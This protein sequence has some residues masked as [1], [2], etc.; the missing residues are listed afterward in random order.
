[1]SDDCPPLQ[2][3]LCRRCCRTTNQS[4][5][6]SDVLIKTKD[7]GNELPARIEERERKGRRGRGAGGKRQT[8]AL[9]HICLSIVF[10]QPSSA[11]TRLNFALCEGPSN[12]GSPLRTPPLPTSPCCPCS[13]A[14]TLINRP[15]RIPKLYASC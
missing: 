9:T 15:N 10:V 3:Y 5:N 8:A 13:C 12:M 2:L 4:H 7:L 6:S 11:A 1:M 14:D